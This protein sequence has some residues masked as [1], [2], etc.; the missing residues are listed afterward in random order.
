MAERK[1]KVVEPPTITRA[2]IVAECAQMV[3]ACFNH[4][5]DDQLSEDAVERIK[6]AIDENLPDQIATNH[7]QAYAQQQ[8]E[9][10]ARQGFVHP[11]LRQVISQ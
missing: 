6:A 2:R 11:R 4:Y 7:W 3:A 5:A 10:V 9:E 8:A 1:P